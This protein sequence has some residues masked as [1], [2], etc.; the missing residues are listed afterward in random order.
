M[1]VE[2]S[3]ADRRSRRSARRLPALPRAVRGRI[4][5]AVV[6]SGLVA[7]FLAVPATA[8][9]AA[10]EITSLSGRADLISGGQDLVRITLPS[11]VSVKELRVQKGSVDISRDFALRSDGSVEGLVSNLPV[12]KTTLTATVRG[13]GSR[14]VLTNHPIGGPLFAGPQIQPWVCTTVENGL[15]PAQDDQCNAP[16][17]IS[18]EYQSTGK[19]AGDYQPYDPS[20]PPSDVATTTTDTGRTVPYILSVE[21][22]TIDRSIFKVYVLA[23]PTKQ[24]TAVAPQPS[25]DRKVFIAF[26]GG[27]GTIHMQ[28]PPT[29]AGLGFPYGPV[30]YAFGDSPADGEISQPELLS[31][32][33]MTAA[34]GLNTLNQN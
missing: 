13:A 15:G 8:S 6:I 21:E 18:Y 32:G 22:G 16:A 12:G 29:Q 4:V 24:W 20:N 11:G 7:G 9:T 30:E 34:T 10:V 2:L 14:L 27:C 5:I 17:K 3:G 33:W 28:A 25:W 31:R 26:G 1:F 19:K 23:D